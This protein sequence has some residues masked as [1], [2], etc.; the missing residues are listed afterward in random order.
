MIIVRGYLQK[1]KQSNHKVRVEQS[2]LFLI[3][4]VLD[5][6]TPLVYTH[7]VDS[8]SITLFIKNKGQNSCIYSCCKYYT[9]CAIIY[10]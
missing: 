4:D 6:F 9:P 3:C 1:Y 8:A 5:R 7:C 2:T 10:L